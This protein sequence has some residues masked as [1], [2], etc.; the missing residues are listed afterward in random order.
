M[1]YD[2]F[3]YGEALARSLKDISHTSQRKRFFTAFGLE[4]L[5][6]F[7]DHL[8]SVEGTILIAVDGHE[9]ESEDNGA[10]GL[11]DK[12]IYSFIVARNTISGKPDTINQ[13]AKQ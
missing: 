9:S 6:N 11:N 4:D 5:I 8:S 10:D 2:H 3:E 12:Q 13:A 1:E 7:E